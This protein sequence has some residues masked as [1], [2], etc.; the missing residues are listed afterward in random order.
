M[1]RSIISATIAVLT[2]LLFTAVFTR[3]TDCNY[4]YAAEGKESSK[5]G[6]TQQTEQGK[7]KSIS[8]IWYEDSIEVATDKPETSIWVAYIKNESGSTLQKKNFKKITSASKSYGPEGYYWASLSLCDSKHGLKIANNKDA[9]LYITTTE[10]SADKTDYKP[11]YTLYA[12]GTLSKVELDYVSLSVEHDHSV[13]PILGFTIKNGSDTKAYS[14]TTNEQEMVN[15]LEHINFSFVEGNSK[16]KY[17]EESVY[18]KDE[19]EYVIDWEK[20]TVKKPQQGSFYIRGLD[21]FGKWIYDPQESTE[22]SI[23]DIKNKANWRFEYDQTEKN[24][25]YRYAVSFSLTGEGSEEEKNNKLKNI[26]LWNS[27]SVDSGKWIR[28]SG[29][30]G[31]YVAFLKATPEIHNSEYALDGKKF[32]YLPKDEETGRAEGMYLLKADGSGP[33]DPLVRLESFG[34]TASGLDI[35]NGE[36][37]YLITFTAMEDAVTAADFSAWIDYW[38]KGDQNNEITLSAGDYIA[39]KKYPYYNFSTEMLNEYLF[40]LA[41]GEKCTLYMCCAGYEK[42]AGKS[43]YRTGKLT[44]VSLKKPAKAVKIKVDVN[45]DTIALKN[46][47]DYRIDDTWYTILPYSKDGTAPSSIVETKDYVP[48]KK[49]T[50]DPTAFTAE[51]ISALEIEKMLE[52]YGEGFDI[53]VRK[54]AKI[55]APASLTEDDESCYAYIDSRESAPEIETLK[56]NPSYIAVSDDKDNLTLPKI[57]ADNTTPFEYIVIASADFA[58]ELKNPGTIVASSMKWTKYKNDGKGKITVDKTKSKY[59]LKTEERADNRTLEEGSYV[60]IRRKG[61]VY[62]EGKGKDV[63]TENY[64]ASHYYTA[65]V[66]K[67]TIDGKE[68]YVLVPANTTITFVVE[69]PTNNGQSGEQNGEQTGNKENQYRKLI[70]PLGGSMKNYQIPTSFYKMY[71][72]NERDQYEIVGW[73]TVPGATAPN[74]TEK[75]VFNEKEVNLYAVLKARGN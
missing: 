53:V 41:S 75:T 50:D 37:D 28:I 44:K 38:S 43:A 3:S 2:L 27:H 66:E 40:I 23:S 22:N 47:F 33:A 69:V 10:P 45:K 72:G 5:D 68:K 9:Y 19:Y 39:L 14:K 17:A 4:V 64:I 56:D 21:F 7:I 6:E 20:S 73:S 67:A 30:E 11:N 52:E 59:M 74:V 24:R 29:S 54:S 31:D 46:G 36:L 61:Y 62:K 16:E 26:D 32:I 48:V 25:L 42:E 65:K 12:G 1:R 51:K 63:Y 57:D 49:V 34:L 8:Y 70:I 35:E 15:A 13:L 18:E 55:G 71:S 60:L 58:A